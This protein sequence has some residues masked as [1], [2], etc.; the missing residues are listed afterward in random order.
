ME[1][2]A[3]RSMQ[4]IT[5]PTKPVQG[6]YKVLFILIDFYDYKFNDVSTPEFYANLL[7]G[8]S[9]DAFS[10]KRYYSDMSG[11]VLQLTMDVC[12]PYRAANNRAYYGANKTSTQGSDSFPATLVREAVI[13]ADADGIDFSPYDMDGDNDV[14]TV[15]IIHAG[16]GEES[17]TTDTDA[18]WSKAWDL[19]SG[20]Y[21][22]DG[23]GRY[24]TASG[25][26]VNIFCLQPEFTKTPGDS[27]IGVFCHEYGH[28]LGLPDL[29]DT[30]YATLGAGNFTLMANGA[31]AGN[32]PGTNPPAW[33]GTCPVPLLAWEKNRLGWLAYSSPAELAFL[34]AFKT[35]VVAQGALSDISA[36]PIA[37][38]ALFAGLLLSGGC[39]WFAPRMRG[40]VLTLALVFLLGMMIGG[41]SCSGTPFSPGSAASSASGGTLSSADA[42]SGG[43]V[44]SPDSSAA[45]SSVSSAAASSV[46]SG[47]ASSVSSGAASSV[48]SGAAS[49]VSSGAASSASGAAASSA[50]GAA[51]SSA[52]GTAAS[53]VS[54]AAASSVSGT[55]ASSASGTAASSVSSRA[56]SA[57]SSSRA[58]SSSLPGILVSLGNVETTR[59]A[60]KIPLGDPADRQYY[61]VENKVR[62]NGTWTEFLPGYYN[63]AGLLI[64][65]IH[66]GVI[67]AGITGNTVNDGA[68]R[69]HGVNIVEADDGRHLW[70]STSAGG[71]ADY[72]KNRSFEPGTTPATFYYN[73]TS[74]NSWSTNST[75]LSKVYISNISAAG[76]TMTFRYSVQ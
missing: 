9:S 56:S 18:I 76:S 73:G 38:I 39:M 64:T 57:A 51:A 36:E 25:K 3:R 5:T 32:K 31:W 70:L 33:D 72:F 37:R 29:Y 2:E 52:S 21:Y 55:A 45:A 74:S 58:S 19:Y 28:I 67:S 69:I 6:N 53:S 11:G 12:G 10:M 61:I 59:K 24:T 34:D 4:R 63:S 46:S 48:S 15:M 66:D 26:R 71:S 44:S 17:I 47:A 1:A 14:D 54:S 68:N 13:A 43:S 49:S 40:T 27:G 41:A 8:T 22:G 75:T 30:T 23:A 65:H 60:V 16:P 35:T 62:V 42:A 50:S 7:N 20:S